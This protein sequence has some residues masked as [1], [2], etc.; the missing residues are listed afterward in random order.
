MDRFDTIVAMD[1][2]Y[3]R[4]LNL[5]SWNLNIS[6]NEK[7]LRVLHLNIRSLRKH[8]DELIVFLEGYTHINVLVLSEINIKAE[9]VAMYHIEGYNMFAKTRE[10]TRGGGLLIY[11]KEDLT[12][13]EKPS[14]LSSAEVLHGTLNM[15]NTCLNIIALYRPPKTNKMQFISETEKL[16]QEIPRNE[17]IIIV[18][19]ININLSGVN[20]RCYASKYKDCL[21]ELGLMCVI[22][23]TE[24]TREA[25]V[26]GEK[27][28]AC[29]DHAWVRAGQ[30]RE[31]V[32]CVIECP[33]SD[34]HMIGVE[35]S[36]ENMQF[37][38][39]TGKGFRYLLILEQFYNEQIKIKIVNKYNTRRVRENKLVCPPRKNYYGSRTNKYLIPML[40]NN[41]D[42]LRQIDI[43]I[44]R[45]SLKKKVLQ[46]L[47]TEFSN[48]VS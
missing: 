8:F 29:I 48:N 27:E 13:V 39:D 21:C 3:Y 23:D 43:Q 17:N 11:I 26:A 15:K 34:H 24:V 10:R 41:N 32:S 2:Q 22:P 36:L 47:N 31:C 9:E 38:D 28:T 37:V 45:Y 6:R 40:Y 30:L 14:Q 44:S 5:S 19:D 25:I 35:I 20:D 12:F 46:M 4:H 7:Y 42:W 16:I 18:G 1:C 33:I